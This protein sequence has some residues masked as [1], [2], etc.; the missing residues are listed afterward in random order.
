MEASERLVGSSVFKTD[1]GFSESLAGSIPVR[2]R[3]MEESLTPLEI[4]QAE[5]LASLP[6]LETE[7]VDSSESLGR[8]SAEHVV[9]P[10]PIPA[11][12]NSAMDGY[13]VVNED[14]SRVPVSL[15]V[16]E[17][18]AAGRE[19]TQPVRPGTAV[20]IMTGAPIPQGTDA[21]VPVELTSVDGDRVRINDSVAAG[22]AIRPAGSVIPS[23]ATVLATGV[24]LNAFHV[25]LLASIGHQALEVS[26]RPT[27][28]IMS[29][30]NEVMSPQM[31]DLRPG[32][33]RDSNRPVMRGLLA[34]LDVPVIDFGIVPDDRDVVRRTLMRAAEEADVVVTSGGVSMGEYDH[35]KSVMSELGTATSWKVAMQPAKPF[36]FGTV[37]GA[38]MF[39]LPGNPVSVAVSF[40]QFLRPGLLTMMGAT[41]IFRPRV[42]A[43]AASDLRTSVAKTVFLRVR[44]E[45][46][47]EQL[48]ASLAGGQGSHQ[49]GGMADADGLAVVERGVAV[50]ESGSPVWV[51]LH[52]AREQVSATQRPAHPAG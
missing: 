34:D 17:G 15:Q 9:A 51:E 29:T 43:V 5:V 25:G 47:G 12:A 14:L 26:R 10:E 44:L 1:E 6:R 37:T 11:F 23:G 28:A 30:G 27:V 48:V 31:R 21:V 19:P 45:Q 38:P 8:V 41:H 35:V 49:L 4:A 42:R 13:A 32:Q 50:L 7:T 20:K 16:V 18:V 46:V 40:E 3:D 52:G 24:R 39:G 2:L 22:N 36:T 33:I